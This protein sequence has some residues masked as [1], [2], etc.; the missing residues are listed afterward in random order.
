MTDRTHL[1][2]LELRLSHE[3]EYLRAATSEGDQ[4]LRRVLIAQ[5]KRE[6]ECEEH[7]I[8]GIV[9]SRTVLIPA[10]T[11]DDLLKELMS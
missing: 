3:R 9:P 2:A 8:L 4:A 7:F 11:D 10:L 6:I 5:I 1:N